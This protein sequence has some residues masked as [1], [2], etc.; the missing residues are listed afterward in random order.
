MGRS[1]KMCVHS[2]KCRATP[3]NPNIHAIRMTR[4]EPSIRTY[5]EHQSAEVN[6]VKISRQSKCL[7][8]KC[9]NPSTQCVSRNDLETIA[10]YKK[11]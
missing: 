1:V 8:A 3:P 6:N 5:V 2:H 10:C 7:R 11:M 9:A 4:V